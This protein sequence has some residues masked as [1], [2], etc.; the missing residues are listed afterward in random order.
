MA[1]RARAAATSGPCRAAS[2]SAS[3]KGTARRSGTGAAGWEFA[4][5]DPRTSNTDTTLMVVDLGIT[6]RVGSKRHAVLDA[7]ENPNASRARRTIHGR[8]GQS[9]SGDFGRAESRLVLSSWWAARALLQPAG[10]AL[11]STSRRGNACPNRLR[12]QNP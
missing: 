9:C 5:A 3:R 4:A 8:V 7:T 12:L 2:W 11:L 1:A 6:L 10:L